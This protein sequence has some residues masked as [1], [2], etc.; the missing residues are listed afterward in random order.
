MVHGM[1]DLSSPKNQ[2]VLPAMRIF[3]LNHWPTR[4]TLALSTAA[5]KSDGTLILRID[6][7][8]VLFIA[9]RI[10]YLYCSDFM[11]NSCHWFW[12]LEN[13]FRLEIPVISAFKNLLPY[14]FDNLT[15]L[16]SPSFFF[17]NSNEILDLQNLSCNFSYC[18]I[19]FLFSLFCFMGISLY[20]A[21]G[22]PFP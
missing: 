21:S 1:W 11:L 13:A 8:C 22:S 18:P 7:Y 3:I 12:P 16:Q 9:L 19:Y 10:F 2:T 14:F 20:L 15:L 17:W 5:E 4:K 6:P